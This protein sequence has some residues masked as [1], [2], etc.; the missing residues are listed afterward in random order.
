MIAESKK[1][2]N[3]RSADALARRES[4]KNIFFSVLLGILLFT[5]VGYLVVSNV[6]INA[7]RAELKS[8]LIK[9]QGELNDLQAK[10]SQLQAQVSET[11]NDAYL[12]KEARETFN[13]K[14]PGEE[15]LTILPA[16]D[17][18]SGQKQASFWQKLIDRIK[19]W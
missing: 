6:K 15:V 1:N 12:E 9:L 3:A 14:K 16:E 19:F 13:L 4:R 5:V 18:G 8:Q 10:K 17:N 11:T 7:R 2:K